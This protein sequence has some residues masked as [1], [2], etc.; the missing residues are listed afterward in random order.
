VRDLFLLATIAAALPYTFTRPYFGLLVFTWLAYMRPQDLC[1]GPARGLRFSLLVAVAM[2][3]GWFVNESRPFQRWFPARKWLMALG[4]WLTVSLFIQLSNPVHQISKW[5]DTIKVLT[6]A[7]FTVGLCDNKKRLDLLIWTTGLSLGF[8]GIKGGLFGLTTGGRILQGPG[9][10][11]KDNNDFCLAMNMILPFLFYLGVGSEN[12]RHRRWLFFAVFL[13]IIAIVITTSR[14]GFLTMAG[15]LGL[16]V[17]KSRHRGI[18]ILAGIFIVVAFLI[19]MPQDVRDRLATLKD[20]KK[21][22]SAAGRLHAWTV[23]INMANDNPYFG[24][25]MQAFVTYFRDYDPLPESQWETG[26]GEASV[27]VAHN[28]YLQLCAESGYPSLGFFLLMILTTILVMRK[29]RRMARKRDGP[30]WITH[31]TNMIEVGLLAFLVG[32]TFLNRA[33]FDLLYHLVAIGGVV[34]LLALRTLRGEDIGDHEER[35]PELSAV[36]R[37]P[38]LVGAR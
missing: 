34:Y 7:L 29:V 36:S 22:G 33:H 12:R 21:E 4:F 11:M 28:S 15:V 5:A 1:W 17:L 31:Y 20:P 13:T 27:R 3:A 35:P 38:Y 24:V 19:F 32:A 14:G 18:G 6:I 2:F 23:A 8:Y 16:F 37:N 26:K 30:I 9:G 10:M 25:G